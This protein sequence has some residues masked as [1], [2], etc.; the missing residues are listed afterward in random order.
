MIYLFISNQHMISASSHFPILHNPT[1]NPT[2]ISQILGPRIQ[3]IRSTNDTFPL[4]SLIVS[5]SYGSLENRNC[6]ENPA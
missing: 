6:Y 1:K 5:T 3:D 2:V 4:Y